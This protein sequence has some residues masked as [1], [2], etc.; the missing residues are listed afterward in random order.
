MPVGMC[1]MRT[2]ES[3]VLTLCPPGPGRAEDV[4]AQ[5][6]RVD[7]DVDLLGL[8]QHE[9]AGGGG[10]DAALRL[11]GRHPLHAVHAALELQPRPDALV[12]AR[13]LTA[14]ATSL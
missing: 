2:A 8:R 6:V 3:V 7:L 5:V 10:V 4:D 12:G 9:H 14:T 1:V 11:G 13:A